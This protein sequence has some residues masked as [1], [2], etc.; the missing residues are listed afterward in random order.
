MRAVSRGDGDALADL[1]RSLAPD[2]YRYLAGMLG[3]EEEGAEAVGETFVRVARAAGRFEEGDVR[4]F[5][6]R[7][8]RRVAA[9][10][11]PTP[12]AAPSELPEDAEDPKSWAQRALRALPVEQR[13]LVVAWDILGWDPE[14]IEGALGIPADEARSRI[15]DARAELLAG[16]VAGTPTVPSEQP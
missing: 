3:D 2:V 1:I 4:S 11:R 15:S 12:A 5:V 6:M 13:E 10:A 9:D 8:A 7:I 14:T 16:P